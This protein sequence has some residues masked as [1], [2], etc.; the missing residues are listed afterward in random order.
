RPDPPRAYRRPGRCRRVQPRP[1]LLAPQLLTGRRP[2]ADHLPAGVQVTGWTAA[3]VC[4]APSTVEGVDGNLRR[5][6][7]GQPKHPTTVRRM[8][9]AGRRSRERC[10]G[11]AVVPPTRP[12][13]GRARSGESAARRLGG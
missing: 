2:R 7:A 3:M 5:H 8:A 4:L 10:D 13:H 11:L 6:G 9:W 12:G 1:V